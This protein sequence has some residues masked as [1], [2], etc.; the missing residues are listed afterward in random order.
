MEHEPKDEDLL[1]QALGIDRREHAKIKE[2]FHEL[3]GL[4]G[5]WI[6]EGGGMSGVLDRAA[7]DRLTAICT[8][9]ER[10]L[11]APRIAPEIDGA[12]AVA[13]YFRPRLA[14]QSV[15]SFW[16]LMLDARARPIGATCVAQ[17]TL[18]ACLVHPREVFAPALRARAAS[19]VVVHNHPSGDP[20]PS[21]EDGILT[22]RLTRAGDVLGIPLIDHVVVAR[23]GFRSIG[24]I[25]SLD[26]SLCTP[27][28]TPARA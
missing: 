6:A 23:G 7:C 25:E 20:T 17:G 2:R 5:V 21:D 26:A 28:A 14:L 10:L 4:E 11:A 9:A 27:R 13:R 18:T 19:I 16:V 3:G 1:M 22:D 8:L 15:E 12:D 24:P